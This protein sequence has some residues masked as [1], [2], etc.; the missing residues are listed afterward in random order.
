M[1]S[2]ATDVIR[3]TVPSMNWT[4]LKSNLIVMGLLHNIHVTIGPISMSLSRQVNRCYSLL[5]IQLCKTT[6]D[7][8]YL[9][10]IVLW[11]LAI[12]NK[13]TKSL[14]VWFLHVMW[15]KCMLTSSVRF[16]SLVLRLDKN[17]I[18]HPLCFLGLNGTFLTHKSKNRISYLKSLINYD[19]REGLYFS[20]RASPFK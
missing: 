12:R 19:F 7:F 15:S 5:G 13:P 9:I 10:F 11:M 6:S 18:N 2:Q 17:K 1:T 14:P 16:C 8:S 3:L 4:G 20:C